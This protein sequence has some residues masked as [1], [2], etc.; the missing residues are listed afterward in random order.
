MIPPR[1]LLFLFILAQLYLFIIFFCFVCFCL[2]SFY[3]GSGYAIGVVGDYG[4]RAV[5][6]Q[7]SIYVGTIL[8]LIFSEA[9]ALYGLIVAVVLSQ[10]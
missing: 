4:V 1:V 9:I 2:C 6:Q 3:L 8:M 10:K 5:A 7:P